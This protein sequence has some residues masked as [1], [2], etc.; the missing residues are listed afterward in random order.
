ME[1]KSGMSDIGKNIKA[2]VREKGLRQGYVAELC[3][4]T[5]KTF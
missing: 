1:V 5:E 3:G 2:I 4:Y